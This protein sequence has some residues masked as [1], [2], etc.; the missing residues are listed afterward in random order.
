M[1]LHL[2][3][4]DDELTLLSYQ[5]QFFCWDNV[6]FHHVQN[7]KLADHL[8]NIDLMFNALQTLRSGHEVILVT[9]FLKSCP[10]KLDECG[11]LAYMLCQ[12]NVFYQKR[13]KVSSVPSRSHEKCYQ[14]NGC[15][16]P[17]YG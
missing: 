7:K 14:Q 1:V 8:D 13:A 2:V 17:A 9:R 15:S 6:L 16:E 10:A 4:L 12:E 11:V 3:R 5:R